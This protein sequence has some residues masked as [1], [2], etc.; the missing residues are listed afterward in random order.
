MTGYGL[1]VLNC[2]NVI[3][4]NCSYY[5][6]TVCNISDSKYGGGVGIVYDT[7]YSNTGYTLELSHSNMT[8]CCNHGRGGGGIYLGTFNEF[9]QVKMLFNH[10]KLSH[11]KAGWGGGLTAN[12]YGSGNVTLVISNCVFFNGSA[13]HGGG[14]RMKV[15]IQS[16]AITIENTDL[17]DNNGQYT[18][19]IDIAILTG[20]THTS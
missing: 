18:A 20:K 1:Y 11:N 10:L 5:H 17:V 3:V 9:F 12:L 4:T 19:E 15:E 13:I 14:I 8:K 2:D 6:S 16:A 7:Q